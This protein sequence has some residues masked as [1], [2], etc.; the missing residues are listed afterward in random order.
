[1]FEKETHVNDGLEWCVLVA[2]HVGV[3]KQV[4]TLLATLHVEHDESELQCGQH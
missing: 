3:D 4:I 2:W 1:M